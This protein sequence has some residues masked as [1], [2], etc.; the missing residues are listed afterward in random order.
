MQCRKPEYFNIKLKQISN[1]NFKSL[2]L[3]FLLGAI[4][5]GLFLIVALLLFPTGFDD[6]LFFAGT[7]DS[8]KFYD[9]AL[10]EIEKL[11]QYGFGKYTAWPDGQFPA[12]FS[13]FLFY[14]FN[15]TNNLIVITASVVLHCLTIFLYYRLLKLFFDAKYA[16]LASLFLFLIPGS[17]SWY[18]QNHKEVFTCLGYSLILF[19]FF[20][21]FKLIS[22]MTLILMG[23]AIVH[24]AKP[25][26][27]SVIIVLLCIVVILESIFDKVCF[28]RMFPIFLLLCFFITPREK[29][30]HFLDKREIPPMGPEKTQEIKKV[31]EIE[32]PVVCG[33]N[34]SNYLNRQITQRI[35]HARDYFLNSHIGTSDIDRTVNFCTLRELFYYLPRS[36]YIGFFSPNFFN[37]KI[38][39]SHNYF[40]KIKTIFPSIENIFYTISLIFFFI[41]SFR[42][43]IFDRKPIYFL[44]ITAPPIIVATYIIPNMGTLYRYRA[45][46][47][48]PLVGFGMC[49]FI[50][51]LSSFLKNCKLK[52][53][54]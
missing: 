31:L 43:I 35:Y 28:K 36:I 26:L 34:N 41:Y 9:M 11:N 2:I 30:F 7:N 32:P 1:S 17:S 8:R 33:F 29:T 14:L 52:S 19:G 4:V 40:S 23:L 6:Q 5:L 51:W 10:L 21:N 50:V 46:T 44:I 39:T 27:T 37:L 24:V 13:T 47:F 49:F 45:P 20:R 18:L 53:N 3:F 16:L 42:A 54:F 15:S 12:G 38:N 25:Y 48:I 22:S